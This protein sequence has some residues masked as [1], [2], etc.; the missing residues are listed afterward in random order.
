MAMLQEREQELEQV[1][2][3]KESELNQGLLLHTPGL[4]VLLR[5]KCQVVPQYKM[6]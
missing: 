5:P 4:S 2:L 6:R 1:E 3:A